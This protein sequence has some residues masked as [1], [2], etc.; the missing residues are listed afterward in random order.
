MLLKNNQNFSNSK[1]IDL[2]IKNTI[3]SNGW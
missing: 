1:I 2:R 3:I